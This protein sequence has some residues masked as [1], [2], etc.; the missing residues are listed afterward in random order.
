MQQN[1]R[2]SLR[3]Y[4]AANVT[5]EVG[6]DTCTAPACQATPFADALR[7][8]CR[9]HRRQPVESRHP[10]DALPRNSSSGRCVCIVE[11]PF[12]W[13]LVRYA[14]VCGRP[15]RRRFEMLPQGWNAPEW[16]SAS[17]GNS[18]DSICDRE[19]RTWSRPGRGAGTRQEAE[20]RAGP[21]L[22]PDVR[23]GMERGFELGGA[24]FSK[25]PSTRQSDADCGPQRTA[26][27]GPDA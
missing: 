16:P 15:L 25:A 5:I 10:H 12:G 21:G 4:G 23:W 26:G 8:R 27:Y 18:G 7:K 19:P 3:F 13:R 1:A 2:P 11:G 20:T 6:Y 22:L 14:V 24:H 17:T 9:P